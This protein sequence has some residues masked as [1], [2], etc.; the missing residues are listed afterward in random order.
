MKQSRDLNS[1]T[2]RA[3]IGTHKGIP[4][5]SLTKFD[6]VAQLNNGHDVEIGPCS[7][8]AWH[9][10]SECIKIVYPEDNG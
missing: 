9:Q 7:C 10:E 2:N 6:E 4:E 3:L 8:G 1:L 5:I